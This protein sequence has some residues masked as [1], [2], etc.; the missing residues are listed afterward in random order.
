MSTAI[1]FMLWP[2]VAF[3]GAKAGNRLTGWMRRNMPE[4][5]LKK[6]LL[7]RVDADGHAGAA[8]RDG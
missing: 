4:G 6:V 2:F 3:L 8:D 1:A 7:L 5:R